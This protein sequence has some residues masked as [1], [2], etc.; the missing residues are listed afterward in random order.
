MSF[1]QL[2]LF[3]QPIQPTPSP[4]NRRTILEKPA[5]I[6]QEELPIIEDSKEVEVIKENKVEIAE[7]KEAKIVEEVILEIVEQ[8]EV[9]A[10]KETILEIGELKEAEIVEETIIEILDQKKVEIVEETIVE[11]VDVKRK[12]GRPRK[13]KQEKVVP[14]IKLKRGRKSYAETY[15]DTDLIDVPSEEVLQEKLYY[16]ITLVAKWFNVTASQLRFWEKEFTI[17][18]PRKNKKGDR[19]FTPDDIKNLKII[20][21]LLRVKKLSLQGAKDYLKANRLRADP[22]MKLQESLQHLKSF[23]LELKANL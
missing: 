17:L 4:K 11:I 22:Q 23:L 12:R 10:I 5:I 14:A 2:D 20:Y 8:K 21:H 1:Q 6:L 18:K 13:P 3:G 7:P 19:L 9:E 15:A 16:S